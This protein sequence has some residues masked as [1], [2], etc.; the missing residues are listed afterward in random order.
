MPLAVIL[1]AII[2]EIVLSV[3]IGCEP[4]RASK[5]HALAQRRSAPLNSGV[6]RSRYAAEKALIIVYSSHYPM[7]G[8][9]IK[10]RHTNE[11]S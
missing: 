1:S 3:I 8:I 2:A 4:G 10:G 11:E 7:P 6:G 5:R 9:A